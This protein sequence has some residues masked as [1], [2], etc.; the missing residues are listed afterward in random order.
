MKLYIDYIGNLIVFFAATFLF[1]QDFII[2]EIAVKVCF[3]NEAN[4]Q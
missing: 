4:M 1:K 2:K 3:N